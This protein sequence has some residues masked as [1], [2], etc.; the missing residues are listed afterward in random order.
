ML[1]HKPQCPAKAVI[2][3]QHGALCK[4][5]FISYFEEKVFKTINKNNLLDREDRICVA[6]SGGKDSL[7]VLYLVKK[8]MKENCFPEENLFVLVIDEGIKNYRKETI[9]DLRSFCRKSKIRLIEVSAKKEFGYEL[10]KAYPIILKKSGKKPCNVCGVWR[11]YLLNKYA[12]KNLA[13]KVVT[14]HN[15]D[16]ES[17]V[18]LM[19]FFKANT[20]LSANLG[21]KSGVKEQEGFVQ[22]VKPLYFCP[23]KEVRLYALLKKFK[24]SFNEC[25]Y[26]EQGYRSKI[27]DMLNDMESKYKGTKQGLINS[28]IDLLP[29][30]KEKAKE[31]YEKIRECRKCGEPANQEVCNACLLLE[32]LKD[33]KKKQKRI[34][35]NIKNISPQ[36]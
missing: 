3:L 9:K 28:F 31:N 11:R 34:K 5:H 30:I 14:G 13:N 2:E 7:T 16:D 32:E 6:A 23:E 12:R 18:V 21:P 36:K 15:L 8:Y 27:R 17:Q 19:N 22:R 20:K 4:N 1:C 24:V 35:Y 33:A 10:D 26:A 25:P 29:L